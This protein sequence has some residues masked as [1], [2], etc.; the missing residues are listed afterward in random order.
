MILG[1]ILGPVLGEFNRS[2]PPRWMLEVLGHVI[3]AA[4]REIAE[5]RLDRDAAPAVVTRSLLHGFSSL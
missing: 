2:L 1:P 5:G 3:V 4:V